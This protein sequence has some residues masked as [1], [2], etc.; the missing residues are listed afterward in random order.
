MEKTIKEIG[1]TTNEKESSKLTEEYF[2]HILEMFKH[3]NQ[4]ISTMP[5]DNGDKEGFNKFIDTLATKLNLK[6]EKAGDLFKDS[7][8]RR[9]VTECFGRPHYVDSTHAELT[10]AVFDLFQNVIKGHH[11]QLQ[12][13][14]ENENNHE[15]TKLELQAL[16]YTK[17]KQELQ[18]E[19]DD[20]TMKFK[21]ACEL[22]GKEHAKKLS[23]EDH[24][25]QL[26]EVVHKVEILK[27]ESELWT[28][29]RQKRLDDAE[30]LKKEQE[31]LLASMTKRAELFTNT[32]KTLIDMGVSVEKLPDVLTTIPDVLKA[33][34]I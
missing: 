11:T 3:F 26:I 9:L 17:T 1:E 5:M 8:F 23:E 6:N 19:I 31:V 29:T 12:H 28:I 2:T 32:C 13:K 33:L 15:K 22:S 27:T 21:R 20:V 34:T 14:L 16:K 18:H 25:M 30:I 4:C 24:K 10:K 7:E